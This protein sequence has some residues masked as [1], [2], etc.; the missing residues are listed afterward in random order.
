M[1]ELVR[2]LDRGYEMIWREDRL[3]EALRGL[4][5]EFEWVVPRHPDGEVRRGPEATIAF[6]RDW[7][8]SWEDLEVEWE[9]L[10]AGESRVLAIVVMRGRGPG[11]GAPVEMRVG[12]LWTFDGTNARRM[13]MYWD[14]D[15]ARA[16]AG[17]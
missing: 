15:E 4:E 10:P 5:P 6:F 9:L 2:I 3:E 1:N 12:Q 14:L 17:L 13:V 16:A 7:R 8:D 11:S